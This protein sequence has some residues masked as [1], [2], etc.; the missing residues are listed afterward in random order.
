MENPI[1][2]KPCIVQTAQ[3]FSVSYKNRFLYS[4]Y[5]PQKAIQKTI[6]DLQI[7]PGT[8]FLCCSPLLFYGMKELLQKLSENCFVAAV[9]GENVLYDFSK[10]NKENQKILEELK[11]DSRFIFIKQ[12]E[13]Q[14]LVDSISGNNDFLLCQKKLLPPETFRRVKRIDFSAGTQFNLDFYNELTSVLENA[15]TTYWANRLTLTKFGKKYSQNLFENLKSLPETIPI[16]KYFKSVQKPVLIFGAGESTD[17]GITLIKEH[18]KDFFIVAADTAMIPLLKNQIIPDAVFLEEAQNVISKA[19]IHHERKNKKIHY[20]AGMTSI[21][22]LKVFVDTSQ[23]SYFTTKY[24]SADFLDN[25][26]KESILPPVNKPFGSVGLTALYYALKFRMNDEVPVYIYG[27]DFSYSAG[28][29]HAKGTIASTQ[30]LADCNKLNPSANYASA[31]VNAY[32]VTGKYGKTYFT[33]RAL[34]NYSIMM[35]HFFA[36]EKNV[37]DSGDCGLISCFERKEPFERFKDFAGGDENSTSNENSILGTKIFAGDGN[38]I[39]NRNSISTQNSTFSPIPAQKIA[40]FFKEE[41]VQLEKLRD[42]L[43]GKENM[44]EKTALEEIKKIA[45]HREYL[46][47]HFPDGQQFSTELSFLKRVRASID[48]FLKLF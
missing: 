44:D 25:L 15:V 16:Q 4:K 41:K 35:N 37:F 32:K 45:A 1:D 3:G 36:G 24:T 19:F 34:E 8:L 38:S 30:R 13:A 5:A 20:F 28:I 29:T 43:T 39:S 47:L 10:E 22:S 21:P 31:F 27:L 14:A 42:I 46:F 40:V 12:S 11:N 18:W 9:E 17:R 26:I 48:F 2:N 33:T 6:E 23:L 7:L